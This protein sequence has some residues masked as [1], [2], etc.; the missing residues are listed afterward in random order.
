MEGFGRCP[1]CGSWSVEYLK[2]YAHCLDCN[3]TPEGNA[4]LDQWYAIEF[5]KPKLKPRSDK[6]KD[7][8]YYFATHHMIDRK[9]LL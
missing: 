8:S 1:R 2:T 3:Y 4:E 6:P 7:R 9:G 5:R